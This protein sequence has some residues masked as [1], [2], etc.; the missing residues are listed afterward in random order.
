MLHGADDAR[1]TRN[2]WREVSK[3]RVD[4]AW[5]QVKVMRGVCYMDGQIR[6]IRA[7]RDARLQDELKAIVDGIRE[8]RG[9]RDVVVDVRLI[10]MAW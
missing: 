10:D 2:A 3:R 6:N 5:L 9:I 8:M 7:N 1:L 4:A